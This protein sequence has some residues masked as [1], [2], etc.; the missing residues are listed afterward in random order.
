MSMLVDDRSWVARQLSL[1][2]HV[3]WIEQQRQ[4]PRA[5]ILILGEAMGLHLDEHADVMTARPKSLDV[6]PNAAPA[7]ISVPARLQ[8]PPRPRVEP[9]TPKPPEPRN[10]ITQL[11]TDTDEFT[12]KTVVRLRQRIFDTAAALRQRI[13]EIGEE[14]SRRRQAEREHAVL[15]A[16]RAAIKEELARINEKLGYSRGPTGRNGAAVAE[17]NRKVHARMSALGGRSV[18]ANWARANG[19]TVAEIGAIKSTVIDAYEAAHP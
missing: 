7:V 1:G 2:K 12:D 6:D 18:V 3:A 19:Y 8:E 16:R 5:E 10:P 15:A 17:R 9:S 14:D 4:V 13:T 11:L